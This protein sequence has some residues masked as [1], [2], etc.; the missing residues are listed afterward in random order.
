MGIRGSKRNRRSARIS[1]RLPKMP[2]TVD[3]V[4]GEKAEVNGDL[5][6]AGGL[7]LDGCIK[8]KVMADSD[9]SAVL[10]VSESA[11]IEGDV[12]VPN[13]VLNGSVEG[14]VHAGERITLSG[15]ARVYGNVYYKVIEMASGA[16]INGQMI[17]D[18]EASE[19][20]GEVSSHDSDISGTLDAQSDDAT[21]NGLYVG[22]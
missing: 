20:T 8:G 14:D 16:M 12:R 6:F 10:S 15:D 11:R 5:R 21:P 9:D 13:V 19:S 7:H 18:G 2:E 1:S 22:S 3:T 17:F 4:I